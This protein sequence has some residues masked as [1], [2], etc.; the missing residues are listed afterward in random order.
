MDFHIAYYIGLALEDPCAEFRII[1]NDKGFDPLIRHLVGHGVRCQRLPDIARAATAVPDAS[2]LARPPEAP[3]HA[4]PKPAAKV[5]KVAKKV[6]A[7]KKK[8][9]NVIVTID[10]QRSAKTLPRPAQTTAAARAK[11]V[12]GCLAKSTKP[13]NVT[14]LRSSIRS[15]FK[16]A[17]DDKA[18]DAVLQ[19]LQSSR[20]V[21]IDGPKVTY[22]LG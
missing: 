8:A 12:V 2:P 11:V 17:L 3:M 16:P 6:A 7:K 19:S 21:T 18:I 15:W 9:K 10:P 14:K 5:A 1:S 20:K 13:A 22:A 4:A